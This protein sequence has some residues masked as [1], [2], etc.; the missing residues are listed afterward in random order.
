MMGSVQAVRPFALLIGA[1]AIAAGLSGCGSKETPTT[2]TTTPA[3]TTSATQ[4][5]GTSAPTPQ[6]TE[7]AVGPG[8]TN[9]FSPTINPV[10][11]G[12]VCAEIRNGVCIR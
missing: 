8:D 11:P 2:T 1:A 4:A 12:S 10:P 9:S 6:P 5:P 3:P 7:K